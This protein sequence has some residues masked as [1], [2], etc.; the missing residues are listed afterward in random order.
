[1]EQL[2]RAA[3]KMRLDER[4]LKKLRQPDRVLDFDLA[5]AM[6]DGT[7]RVFKAYRVQWD[8]SRGPYKGGIR[9]HPAVDLDEVKA[10]AFWMTVKT[11]VLDLPLGGGKGGVVVDPKTLSASEL[12]RLTR[13][14]ARALSPHVGP[15]RDIPAPDVG[16]SAREMGWFLDEYEKTVGHPAPGAV[17]GKPL[18]L[19][20]SLGREAATGRGAFFLL[21]R[22][23]EKLGVGKGRLVV[24]GFGNVGSWLA[25]LAHDDGWKIVGLS[26][27][28]GGVVNEDGLD[29]GALLAA[30]KK[31]ESLQEA[32]AGRSVTQEELLEAECDVLAPAA[33][34]NQITGGNA[35]RL[36]CKALLEAANGPTT[37]EADA[38]LERPGVLVVPDVLANA[39]G[40]TVSAYEWTQ[41]VRKERWSEE[42]ING[43]LEEAMT[44]AWDGVLGAQER[45][46]G[47]MRE[48]AFILAL[49][50]LRDALTAR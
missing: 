42:E 43:R 49:E 36:R 15:E 44:S 19:G 41:N 6:D 35:G 47:S 31:G 24:Q 37:P 3:A 27:S 20:G 48:S 34:E 14:F 13:A 25:R 28:K 45:H 18:S 32:G 26:D 7:E 5:I 12:E 4:V 40:V 2:D 29:P 22:L 9:Y 38:I 50:R 17:T 11:A 16:T 46:G 39:G 8:G 10:L 21:N 30:K 23:G 33:L 1:M